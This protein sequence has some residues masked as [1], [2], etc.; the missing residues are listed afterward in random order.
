MEI[1]ELTFKYLHW[2]ACKEFVVTVT[3][4]FCTAKTKNG[5]SDVEA[6]FDNDNGFLMSVSI[7]CNKLALSAYNL[8]RRI[9]TCTEHPFR[10]RRTDDRYRHE[11]SGW[12]CK[13]SS[14]ECMEARN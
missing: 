4:S 14:P 13:S 11:C 6:R 1:Q 12:V 5:N 9:V 8:L 3:V 2:G 10:A 7:S